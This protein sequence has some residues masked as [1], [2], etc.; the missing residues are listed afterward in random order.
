LSDE[1]FER[2]EIDIDRLLLLVIVVHFTLSALAAEIKQQQIDENTWRRGHA[3]SDSPEISRET[4]WRSMLKTM[5]PIP[6]LFY[7]SK[8]NATKSHSMLWVGLL[9]SLSVVAI[10]AKWY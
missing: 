5:C 8:G 10:I 2:G 4:T 1:V 7:G 6:T 3:G 9:Y